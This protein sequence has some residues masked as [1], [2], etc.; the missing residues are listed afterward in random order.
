MFSQDITMFQNAAWMQDCHR[1]LT[2][3][4][5]LIFLAS[6]HRIY[7]QYVLYVFVPS[8]TVEAMRC[9]TTCRRTRED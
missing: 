8:I 6:L 2:T 1:A 9:G 3:R 4:R 5:K 7:G